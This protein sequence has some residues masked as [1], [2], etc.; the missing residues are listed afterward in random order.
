VR[1]KARAVILDGE[2]LVVTSE[3][4]GGTHAYF[5]LPGGRVGEREE[6]EHAVVRE[7][8]EETGLAVEPERLLYVAEVTAPHRLHELTL[9]FLCRVT[10]D[11]ALPEQVT[12]ALDDDA[13][14]LRPPLLEQIA[15]DARTGW[16]ETPRWLGNIWTA[17]G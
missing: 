6:V 11:Q 17:P 10:D 14:N 12:L 4:R 1:V 16:V 9:V 13:A 15:R 3:R 8:R 5:G 2:R 7:V